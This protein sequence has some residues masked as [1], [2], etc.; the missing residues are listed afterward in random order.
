MSAAEDEIKRLRKAQEDLLSKGG[1]S[2]WKSVEE[3][4]LNL[5][6]KLLVEQRRGQEFSTLP[7]DQPQAEA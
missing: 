5:Q 1:R 2:L 7:K 3:K 4:E 6:D